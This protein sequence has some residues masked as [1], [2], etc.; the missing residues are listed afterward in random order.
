MRTVT[1]RNSVNVGKKFWGCRN[2]KNQLEKGRNFFKWVGDKVVDGRNLKIERKRKK[3]LKL[4][5]G[6]LSI[7]GLLKN[8]IVLAVISLGLNLVFV[9][10]YLK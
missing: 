4:K 8:A 3:I 6:V 1:Y 5:N 7:R 2:Y 10:L 9:T